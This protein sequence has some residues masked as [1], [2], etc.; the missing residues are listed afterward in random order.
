MLRESF[1]LVGVA[2]L[3]GLVR[4]LSPVDRAVLRL[5]LLTL[6]TVWVVVGCSAWLFAT[7]GA[8][9]PTALLQ[10]WWQWDWDRLQAIAQFGYDGH[11]SRYLTNQEAFFPGFPLLLR[12]VHAVVPN[13]VVAGLLISFVAGMVAVVALAR[14]AE[15]ERSVNEPSTPVGDLGERAVLFLLLSPPAVFLAAGYTEALFLAFALPAWLAARRGRWMLASLLAAGATATRISGLFLGAALAV[16]FLT[17]RDG[18]RRW[19][20]AVWLALPVGPVL[21]YLLYQYGRTGDW[22][23]WLH[24]QQKG[25]YRE[26]T[27]PVDAYLHTWHAAFGHQQTLGYAWMF[28]AELVAMAVGV[29]LVGWLLASRRWGELTYVGLQVVSLGT[30]YWYMSVPRATL[31]WWPLWIGLAQWS[32]RQ[33]WLRT[34]YLTLIAPFM[35]IFTLVFALGRWAG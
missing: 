17:A 3:G 10:R 20:E 34:A 15:L 28:R 27:N 16:E 32:L 8:T 21:L 14:L 23:S 31:L 25:W 9:V 26:F 7:R 19:R 33:P 4:T 5:R 11:P 30:S 1:T 6:L 35:V 2:R 12:G 29:L 22:A 13:W 18:R 24:A